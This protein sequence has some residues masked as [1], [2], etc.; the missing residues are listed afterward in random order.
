MHAAPR[1]GVAVIIEQGDRVLLIR[2]RG[3]HGGGT[4]S[5]PGGHLD[6]GETPEA[7]AIRETAEETGLHLDTATYFALTN[8]IFAESG[9]H[10]ITLWM[11]GKVDAAGTAG[12]GIHAPDELDAVGWYAWTDLP[13]PLF[14]PLQNLLAGRGYFTGY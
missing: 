10:Y 7:C 5:T 11:R 4:W 9:L 14:L 1:V 8:D 12:A 6:Y 13:E 2:R 3:A